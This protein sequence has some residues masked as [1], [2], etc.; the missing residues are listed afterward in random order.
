MLQV[1]GA[2]R[3]SGTTSLAAR[4]GPPS[5]RVSFRATW[6]GTTAEEACTLPGVEWRS[7]ARTAH[8]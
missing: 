3:D 6:L 1:V 2:S 8:S 5:G 7:C 4:L